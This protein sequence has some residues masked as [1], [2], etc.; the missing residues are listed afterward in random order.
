[1]S[2]N[3]HLFQVKHHFTHEK[4]TQREERHDSFVKLDVCQDL[5]MQW[6]NSL[7]REDS[8]AQLQRVV[9]MTLC[10]VDYIQ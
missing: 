1:M 5:T 2:L 3:I 7:A 8:P 4:V 6:Q 9:W 10:S